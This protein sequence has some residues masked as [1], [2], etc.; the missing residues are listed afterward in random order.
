MAIF[1]QGFAL[2]V[3]VG[4]DLPNTV[5]DAQGLADT[6]KDPARCAYPS[7]QVHLL[8]GEGAGRK[9]VLSALDALSRSADA[10][11]T[12]LVYFSGHGYRVASPTGESYY[13][14][15]YGYDL[16]RL[17]QTAISGAEFT[18]RLRAIPA[19]KLLVLLDCCH[20]GGVGEAKAPGLGLAKSP[21]PPEA[22]RLLAEGSGRVLIA[23]SQEDELSFAGRPYSAFTLALIEAL[24]GVGVAKEDGYTRVA[25]MALH[26]REVVPGRTHGRQHP[27]LNFE[28]ADNFALAYYAGGET[29]PK[30][31]PFRGEPEIEPEPGAWT[32]FDQHGQTVQGPQ[33]NIAGDVQAP[34][35]SGVTQGPVAV[36]D[37]VEQQIGHRVVIDGDIS[38]QVAVGEGIT[39]TQSVGVPRPAAKEADRAELR[40]MLADLKVLVAEE[41]PPEKKNAAL[42][43]LDE[44]EEALNPEEFDLATMEYVGR[45]YGKHASALA[46]AVTGLIGHPVVSRLAEAGSSDLA[47][48]YR[49]RFG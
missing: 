5:D 3:G 33:T 2:V 41:A 49:R 1:D 21:L 36:G 47:A 9:V 35:F 19:R 40:G 11:S 38:G 45:W 16:N 7:Q 43:R 27:I 44:L 6:L 8:S 26:A 12:V 32:L 24:C 42:E 25:D 13:L 37:E 31:V 39:Q 23:S 30:A 34:V 46:R 22:Q 18:E 10:Q 28:G 48:E 20:A 15:P 17:H 4:A 14:M 29:Q